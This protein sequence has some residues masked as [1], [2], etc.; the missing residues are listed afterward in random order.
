M[1]DESNFEQLTSQNAE[2]ASQT[3]QQRQ[4]LVRMHQNQ[5]ALKSTAST[6][7]GNNSRL[8]SLAQHMPRGPSSKE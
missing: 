8:G 6:L 1:N 2:A 3:A 7:G 5:L 4:D